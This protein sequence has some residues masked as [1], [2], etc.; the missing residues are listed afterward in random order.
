MTIHTGKISKIHSTTQRE[1]YW[2]NYTK[3]KLNTCIYNNETGGKTRDCKNETKHEQEASKHKRAGHKAA[4]SRTYRVHIHNPPT[5]DWGKQGK[6]PLHQG[7]GET[8]KSRIS[9]SS[10]ETTKSHMY[11]YIRGA[12]R[13]QLHA[14]ITT[15][16][17][18][19]DNKIMHLHLQR[20]DTKSGIYNYSRARREGDMNSPRSGT[21]RNQ[22]HKGESER[23]EQRTATPGI[24]E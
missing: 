13:Q 22:K 15:S 9:I 18:W 5:S 11:N 10:G 19:G 4:E 20:E 24:E 16:G 1:R 3:R 7:C 23:E 14:S 6:Q 21:R 12:G 17:A 8:I 2:I